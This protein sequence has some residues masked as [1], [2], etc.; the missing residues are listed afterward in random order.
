MAGDPFL[1]R[2]AGEIRQGLIML[3]GDNG[4]FELLRTGSSA[5]RPCAMKSR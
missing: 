3:Q 4:A 5:V 2:H 1:S